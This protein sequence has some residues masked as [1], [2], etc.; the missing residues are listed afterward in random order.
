[1]F[2]K[3][4][5]SVGLRELLPEVLGMLPYLVEEQWKGCSEVKAI[6]T[7]TQEIKKE[8]LKAN[9]TIFE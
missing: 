1:M 8:E 5:L 4:M 9:D 6:E 7:P 3:V 2:E